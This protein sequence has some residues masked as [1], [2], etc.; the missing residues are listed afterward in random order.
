[1]Q[2]QRAPRS[3]AL[4]QLKVDAAFVAILPLEEHVIGVRAVG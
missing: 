2:Q 3:Y 1:M 4:T